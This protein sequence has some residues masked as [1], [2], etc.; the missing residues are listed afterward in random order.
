MAPSTLP[1]ATPLRPLTVFIAL[2]RVCSEEAEKV[3]PAEI[4]AAVEAGDVDLTAKLLAALP[5]D[6]ISKAQ[7]KKMEKN[8][9]IQQKKLAKGGGAA[10]AKPADAAPKAAKAE[11]AAAKVATPAAPPPSKEGIAGAT[12]L[13]LVNAMLER[14]AL[15]ALPDDA[16]AKLRENAAALALSISPGV[17]ALRNEAYATGFTAHGSR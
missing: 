4:L 3:V 11:K 7:K 14:A 9:Q 8:A 17:T 12:E 6:A 1:P 15:L 2:S 5:A 16:V 13:E 10:P